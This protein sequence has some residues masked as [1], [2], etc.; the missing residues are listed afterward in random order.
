MRIAYTQLFRIYAHINGL[1]WGY[2]PGTPR[3]FEKTDS[4][5]NAL[6]PP[7]SPGKCVSQTAFPLGLRI[8]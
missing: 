7:P 2:T 5:S 1:P 3:D 6:I 4:K 8:K